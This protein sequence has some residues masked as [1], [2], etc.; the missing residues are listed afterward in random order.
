M[1][2]IILAGG[3]G[4]RLYPAT[5]IMTKQ[6]LPIYDKPLIYYPLSMLMLARIREILIIS[7]PHDI[8]LY[9]QLF[10]DGKQ[11]GL[12]FSYAIQEEPRGLADAFIIGE[13][14]IGEDDVMLILGDN[15]FWGAKMS[16]IL[17]NTVKNLKGATVFG[18]EV[19]DPERY[20]VVEFDKAGKVLSLEE[21]PKKPKSNFAV[22][23]LYCYHADVVEKAK[24]LK[25]SK[26]G[27]LEITDLNNIYLK[28]NQL[29][30]ELLGRGVAW[31]DTGTHDSFLEASSFVSAIQNRQ[32]QLMSSPE[33]IAY[34]MGYIHGEDLEKLAKPMSKTKY[35][36][37][38]LKLAKVDVREEKINSL[39]NEVAE[40]HSEVKNNLHTGD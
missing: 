10:G 2:G 22:V 12:S 18:Y 16:L 3:A 30:V 36:Q 33:E 8:P 17:R 6:L 9:K 4:T 5:M 23:G 15:V 26:R 25:P 19:S 28:E 21:K 31:L 13:E 11:W 7:T 39:L 24:G 37:Y 1:K 34:R 40:L 38:L 32:G 20:G 27:E 14:F 29:N 35:G